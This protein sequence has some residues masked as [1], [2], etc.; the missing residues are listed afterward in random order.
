[1]MKTFNQQAFNQREGLLSFKFLLLL[2]L[3][4]IVLSATASGAQ[5]AILS[6]TTKAGVGDD[7][8]QWINQAI[9]LQVALTLLGYG[10]FKAL[11]G[12]S[13]GFFIEKLGPGRLILIAATLIFV[14]N[15]PMILVSNSLVLSLSNAFIGAG[16]GLL[17]ATSIN[18]LT[19][20]AGHRG[21]A[22]AL[23]LLEFII[24]G[25]YSLGSSLA[26]F[27]SVN[28]NFSMAF[29]FAS[30][31]GALSMLLALITLKDLAKATT[32]PDR[33]DPSVQMDLN[34]VAIDQDNKILI[35]S[36][37]EDERYEY[38]GSSLPSIISEEELPRDTRADLRAEEWTLSKGLIN[39]TVLLSYL[40][41]HL[42]KIVDSL[43]ILFVPF[44]LA[45]YGFNVLEI[46][47]CASAYTLGLSFLMPFTGRI[48]DRIGRK[49]PAMMGLFIEG[50]M[51]IG[52]T[53]ISEY[54]LILV[55]SF[56]AGLGEAMYYPIMPVISI[57][58]APEEEKP[59][60]IGLYRLFSDIGYVTGPLVVGALAQFF[61]FSLSS[62]GV[63]GTS[64][65]VLGLKYSFLLIGGLL[66]VG[67][68]GTVLLLKETRP[69][70]T[71]M[72][73]ACKHAETT[74]KV[75]EFSTSGIIAYLDGR[76]RKELKSYSVQ[77]KKLEIYADELLDAMYQSIYLSVR[78]APDD[79]E[80]LRI[81]RNLDR[82]AGLFFGAFNR[83]RKVD[84]K[85]MPSKIKWGL[86]EMAIEVN[87]LM[88]RVVTS[89]QLVEVN[90][91]MSKNYIQAAGEIER[92]IDIIYK[93]ISR[94]LLKKCDYLPMSIVL[95]LKDII[96]MI[97]KA[98][99]VSLDAAETIRI[100]GFKYST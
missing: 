25:G 9:F 17:F 87:R 32:L 65:A 12:F 7:V 44:L 100:L 95:N 73:N 86:R 71:Q 70:W 97:E 41:G 29:L 34:A 33:T 11:M 64:T 21:R 89:L 51:I 57:D 5:R 4:I 60:A 43:I 45:T 52:Y 3:T 35:S 27:I 36:N 72:D 54:S 2:I 53:L 59:K 83:L 26:G 37:R 18:I 23:G 90:A 14:G 39:T 63:Q 46:A 78:K 79:A 61:Y 69:S 48:S 74:K 47:T 76:S 19:S 58:L 1:M 99:D 68:L 8:D 56:L 88:D 66:F 28:S 84:K 98:S 13:S 67:C 16:Q 10:L 96:E 6:L 49:F 42:S 94:E 81:G 77:A 20:L 40:N 93:K 92:E 50:T 62:S 80:F 22:L 55:V 15:L 38:L 31:F 91:Y 30:F 82:S 75:I 85:A 24:Y